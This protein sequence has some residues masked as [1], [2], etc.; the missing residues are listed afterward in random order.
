M[1]LPILSFVCSI[2]LAAVA[3]LDAADSLTAAPPV[4]VTGTHGKFDFIK[5]DPSRGRLLAS[6]TENGSLDVIDEKTSTLLKSIPT[7]NAQGVA[8]DDKNGLYYVSTSKPPKMVIVDANK[9][10]VAGE[11]ALP[12]PADILAYHAGTN[13]VFVCN[14]EKPEIWVIDPVAKKIISTLTMPGAGMEDLGF[15]DQGAFLFQALK[16]S[17]LIAKIDPTVGKVVAT[18]PTAPA[19]KPHGIAI[20]PGTDTVLVVG[21]NG[22]LILMS[23]AD[24]KILAS[25]DVAQRV[26]EIAYDPGLKQVYCASGTGTISVVGVD[27]NKLTPLPSLTSAP[28]AHS[29]AVDPQTHTVWIAFA[30]D[31]KAYVQAF[32]GK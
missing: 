32:P 23:L 1:K 16:E 22:K 21:G 13:R 3:P 17:S 28:G 30:K 31:G 15:N 18:W 24:G 27:Q 10:E 8:I 6:H 9:L 19:E 2:L 11:V 7:G 5:V 4:E 25:A 14:D 29:V 26:D 12:D 20:I